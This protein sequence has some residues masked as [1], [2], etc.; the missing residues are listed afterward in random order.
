MLVFTA[1]AQLFAE[2]HVVAW[3]FHHR[4]I[5][6]CAC[7]K[8]KVSGRSKEK[9]NKQAS[10]NTHTHAQ[11]SHTNLGLAQARPN[12]AIASGCCRNYQDSLQ[13]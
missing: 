1:F 4:E 5:F 2:V 3:T 11:C 9:S 8:F 13:F 6:E 10:I 12:H 7:L